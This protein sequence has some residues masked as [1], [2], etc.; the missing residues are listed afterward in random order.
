MSRSLVFV[1]YPS[2]LEQIG[3]TIES[4]ALKLRGAP[5]KFDIRTWKQLDVPGR[6]IIEGITN[7]IDEADFIVADITHL[8][9]NVTFE[10]GYAIGRKKRVILILN[11]ALQPQKKEISQLGV[12]D[13]LG[14]KD[15]EN[16]EQLVEILADITDHEPLIL[17]DY[18]IDR[19]APIYILNTLH[20]TDASIRIISKI[21]KS[22]FKFRSFDPGETPRLSTIEA[23]RNVK[24]SIAVVI[25]LLSSVATDYYFNNLRGAFLAGL[26]YG[27]EKEVLVL[28]EGD[29][30]VPVDYR[31]FVS[32]YKHPEDV[33]TYI[34]DLA[35]TVVELLQTDDGIKKARPKGL[36]IDL[37]LGATAAENEMST[38]GYYYVATD[39]FSQCLAGTI[40][41]GV[42]RKGS[43]KSALFFQ[44]RDNLRRD[45][46][47]VVL[48]LKPE[49]HQL[50]RF[51]DIL[52]LLGEAVQEHVASAFWEY[53]L[54]LEVCNK[55]LQKD[56]LVHTR[57]HNIYEPYQRLA[58]YYKNDQ[59]IEEADFSERMLALVNRITADFENRYGKD[60]DTYLSVNEVNELIYKHDIP[61]LRNEL[62]QYLQ[63]KKSVRLLFDN[64]DKGWPTRGVSKAD[65]IIFRG[66]LDS[67]RKIERHFRKHG[68]DFVTLI[69][70]R[71]DVFEL[72][73]SE[74]PDRGKESKV[75]LDWTDP[76][77]LREIVRRRLI[78]NG[79]SD[80]ISFDN[81]WHQICVSHIQ[82]EDTFDYMVNRSLLR[83]RNLLTIINYSKS[84]AVNLQHTKI[85]EDDIVKAC[86]SYSADIGNEIGLEI[87]DVFPQAE[88]VLYFFIDAPPII[89][90]E[91]VRNY[92]RAGS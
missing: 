43:G 42:G 92:I 84:N 26:S 63:K 31:D 73:I 52:L 16:S 46:R 13:T 28:Q 7:K 39:E 69:F 61:K 79:F 3:D 51:R 71:N 82:G 38:L 78:Y 75:S 24:Q 59:Y 20:K 19:S 10:V 22:R 37:D 5:Y 12:F 74:T 18:Q 86:S 60:T 56:R 29:E 45:K 27:F 80:S 17:P 70:V 4:T 89:T 6:F 77:R 35:P 36:L 68:I 64:I 30:P 23:W 50:K 40:R 67:T 81:A 66:L 90:L 72:L 87:R 33:D 55:L 49:G 85:T 21:K 2:L 11:N 53:V 8:N 76:D 44:L 15:Y 1:A 54:L 58:A 65:T 48:D 32:V 91:Q 9:F 34:N 41:L 88:D 47:N 57:D 62:V 83:P 14:Y 25:N